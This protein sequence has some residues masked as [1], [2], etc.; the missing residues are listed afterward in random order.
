MKGLI[1]ED[2]EE[3]IYKELY[4]VGKVAINSGIN[5]E[6]F[7]FT[8]THISEIKNRAVVFFNDD[9]NLEG[10]IKLEKMQTFNEAEENFGQSGN[11]FLM[12]YYLITNRMAYE[13]ITKTYAQKLEH[14]LQILIESAEWN[15]GSI[16]RGYLSFA[17]HI[18]GFFTRWKDMNQIRGIFEEKYSLY[19]PIVNRMLDV[20]SGGNYKNLFLTLN[21]LKEEA[22]N[23]FRKGT[24]V[25]PNSKDSGNPDIFYR[26]KFH[27]AIKENTEF[28]NYMN[29]NNNFLASRLFTIF[30]YLYNKKIGIKN[31]DRYL[32]AYLIYR[33][34]EDK[35]GLNSLEI[36]K[37]FRI[38]Q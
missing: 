5:F 12:R 33:G 34:V 28:A 16:E 38:E 17:S 15:Y 11:I 19:K 26:S 37:Q 30:F 23:E 13:N 27:S 25:F 29:T 24:L 36:I 31:L 4:Q 22:E 6:E 21:S 32:L 14:A 8:N 3:K 2:N 20:R 35:L 7:F 9:V 18:N 10:N 1:L